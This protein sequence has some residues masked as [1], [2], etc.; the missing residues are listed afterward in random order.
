MSK[1]PKPSGGREAGDA[2]AVPPKQRPGSRDSSSG[3]SDGE[4]GDRTEIAAR[5]VPGRPSEPASPA[6]PVPS[7]DPV[8]PGARHGARAVDRF[9]GALFDDRFE[10]LERVAQG[11]VG[12]IYRAR[13]KP[14]GRIVAL[15][16]LDPRHTV[17]D[18]VFEERFV[19]EASTAS[20][21]THPN[22]VTVFDYGCTDEDV[23]FIAMEWVD[24]RTLQDALNEEQSLPP[25]RAVHIAMQVCRSL[26]EAHLLGLVHRDLKPANIMLTA[27]GDEADYVKVLDFG[28]VRDLAAPERITRKG[29]IMGS[30]KYMA[31]EQIRNATID[32]RTDIY[33]VGAL[34]YRMLRGRAPFVRQSDI[35]TMMAHLRDPVPSLAPGDEPGTGPHIPRRLAEIVTRCLAKRPEERFGTI[36][37]LLAA[38]KTVASSVGLPVASRPSLISAP[39]AA[40]VP[41][42]P[43]ELAAAVS[44]QP[45]RRPWA[46]RAAVVLCS[47]IVL[48]GAGHV[49][50]Q[51]RAWPEGARE[52]LG[53]LIDE[54]P[55]EEVDEQ[56]PEVQR[57]AA[58]TPAAAQFS[59]VTQFPAVTQSPA[60]EQTNVTAEQT[61]VTQSRSTAHPSELPGAAGPGAGNPES[62]ELVAA[63]ESTYL[64]GAPQ[65]VQGSTQARLAASALQ[66]ER[67]PTQRETRGVRATVR[68][69]KP[70][71]GAIGAGRSAGAARKSGKAPGAPPE[72][73]SDGSN[74][75]AAS[76]STG[77]SHTKPIALKAKTAPARTVKPTLEPVS[78]RPRKDRRQDAETPARRD[79]V[80]PRVQLR[81]LVVSGPIPANVIRRAL[82][83]M[84]G[85]FSRCYAASAR[86]TGRRPDQD[87]TVSLYIGQDG[88]VH[89]ATATGASLERLDDC[90]QQQTGRVVSRQPP[91]VGLARAEFVLLFRFPDRPILDRPRP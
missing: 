45:P 41:A 4:A 9:V 91:D 61:N 85:A 20:R 53:R 75:P 40:L 57:G 13:Q 38:L 65:A 14:L 29:L 8:T 52:L 34:M 82:R 35:D 1:Q 30:P 26:R 39:V 51:D 12:C 33:A 64:P 60:A 22:T 68:R 24:G 21:L 28:L 88:R 25:G 74:V 50:M 46:L 10:I 36:D 23:C 44:A 90:V 73:C 42:L 16:I 81:R 2:P 19:L 48:G 27:H 66:R 3:E 84:L 18:A 49:L 6:R 86:L 11:S 79:R 5:S 77:E 69:A 7:T 76:P 72:P 47:G 58:P 37:E 71:R 54:Q 63:T 62:F 55:P 17:H 15:K 80:H 67:A 56:P 70:R 78:A 43:A 83:R 31:P 89:E 59:A 32:G 87:V